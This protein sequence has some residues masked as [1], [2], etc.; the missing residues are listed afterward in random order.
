MTLDAFVAAGRETR[1]FD[2]P[3]GPKAI[4]K[5]EVT[6]RNGSDENRLALVRLM[7]TS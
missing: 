1:A 4:K 7:G 5:V 2:V 3:G 6:Y